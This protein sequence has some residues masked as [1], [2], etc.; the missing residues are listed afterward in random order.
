MEDRVYPRRGCDLQFTPFSDGEQSKDGGHVSVMSFTQH[1]LYGTF[2]GQCVI[3]G[4]D[5]HGIRV[6]RLE[7]VLGAVEHVIARW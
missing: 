5:G 2:S 7:Q 4:E 3:E 1:F 6:I